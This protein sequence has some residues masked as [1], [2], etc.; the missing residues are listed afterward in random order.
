MQ[1]V[2]CLRIPLAKPWFGNE[3]LHNVKRV[4]DS[5]FVSEFEASKH[6]SESIKAMQSIKHCILVSNATVALWLS[7]KSLGIKKGDSVVVPSFTHPASQ[8]AVEFCG[9]DVI[10][11]DVDKMTYNTN[12][13]FIEEAVAY[14]TKAIMPV[15]LFG[16]GMDMARIKDFCD[17]TGIHIIEDAACSLGAVNNGSRAGCV[18]DSGCYSFHAKKLLSTGE[19]GAIVTNND[20]LAKHVLS[21]KKFGFDG[22]RDFLVPGLNFKFPDI[23]A[24]IGIAQVNKFP[25]SIKARRGIAEYYGKVLDR[26]YLS[27]PF[28]SKNSYHV[29]QAYVTVLDKRINRDKV[30]SEMKKRG[31]ETQIGTYAVHSR[32]A[33]GLP[34]DAFPNSQYLYEHSLALPI[35]YG[36]TKTELEYVVNNLHEVL[37]KC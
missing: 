15:H 12:L 26:D 3:E 16:Q 34:K 6:L 32:G 13:D 30:I 20:E 25:E 37:K 22:Y 8:F 2:Y 19:G 4:L 31:I 10:F 11:C 23:L 17:A 35:W 33:Y 14:N 29:F 7:L 1:E 36:M 18:G 9:A 5:G 27:V 21:L 28:V 24:A